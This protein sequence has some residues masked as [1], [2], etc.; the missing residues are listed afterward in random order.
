[1]SK[2]KKMHKRNLH[3]SS[4]N[5]AELITAYSDLENYVFTNKFQNSTID[6][7]NPKA[8]KS[9][10][11]ALLFFYY[12]LKYWDFPDTNL[13]PPIPSRVDYLHYLADLIGTKTSSTKHIL[14]IGTGANCIYPLLGTKVYHWNFTGT[15]ID[16]NS[17]KI[18][19]Q[20]V[21]KNGLNNKIDLRFQQDKN[22]ILIG[23]INPN[24]KFDAV[25]CNPPFYKSLE[26]ANKTNKRKQQNLNLSSEKRNFSGN[27]NELWYKGGEKAF[28]HNYL[29][30]SSLFKEN[31]KWF[32]SLVNKKEHVK[33]MYDSLKKLKATQIKTID[34]EHGNKITRI[35][36]WSFV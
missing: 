8:V 32:T 9:L 17:L 19:Q 3:T 10:N 24:D 11:T 26:E 14:D 35:V 5:F 7:S 22:N 15:D 30:Q 25:I 1:M 16:Q 12:D 36:A 6:F 23:I 18:A 31:C 2:K 28:L 34:M 29:Y 13:C 21:D 33:S 4:Y 20:I 27:N